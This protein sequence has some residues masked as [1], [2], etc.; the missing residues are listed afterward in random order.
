MPAASKSFVQR[1]RKGGVAAHDF[2]GRFHFRPKQTINVIQLRK[3][4][5]GD[6]T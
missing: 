3:L 1:L 4:N 6:L 5:T 2:T